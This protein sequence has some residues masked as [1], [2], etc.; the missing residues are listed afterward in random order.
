MRESWASTDTQKKN[1]SG[2]GV[3][4]SKEGGRARGGET[5]KKVILFFWLKYSEF[6]SEEDI[7]QG[8]LGNSLTLETCIT[9]TFK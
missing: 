1:L 3:L 6:L 7:K 2:M 9:N 4:C 8:Q 5:Q